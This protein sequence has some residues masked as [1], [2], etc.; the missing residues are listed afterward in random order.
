M[1]G[2]GYFLQRTLTGCSLI[3][4]DACMSK[5]ISVTTTVPKVGQKYLFRLR[6]DFL[7]NIIFGY[8]IPFVLFFEGNDF[9]LG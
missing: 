9:D 3:H 8:Q 4:P 2:A 7:T 1:V 6:T 5:L